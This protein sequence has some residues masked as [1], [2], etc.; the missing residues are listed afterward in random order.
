MLNNTFGR[1]K[2]E[3]QIKLKGCKFNGN[4]KERTGD[5]YAKCFKMI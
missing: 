1:D 4:T 3:R 2:E 5:A